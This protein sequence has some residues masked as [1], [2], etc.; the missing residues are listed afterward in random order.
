MPIL[1]RTE[2]KLNGKFYY[3]VHCG[4]NPDYLGSG[5]ALNKAIAKHGRENF[6]RRTIFQGTEDECFELERIMV[7]VDFIKRSDNYNICEGGRGGFSLEARSKG[8]K[9][10]GALHKGKTL[11][12]ETKRKISESQKGRDMSKAWKKSAENRKGKIGNGAKE[13]VVDGVNYPTI[14]AASKATGMCR[15][16]ISKN[17]L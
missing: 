3:G 6:V 4:N 13:V 1:Y 10:A 12:D 11:S 2:N 16:T 7:D 5:V 14:T 15:L 17:Y 9:I 8:G